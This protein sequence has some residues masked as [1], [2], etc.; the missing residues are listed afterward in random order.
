MSEFEY[1]EG[2][3]KGNAQTSSENPNCLGN[4]GQGHQPMTWVSLLPGDC[5]L[6]SR[7][8][9][10]CGW[11]TLIDRASADLPPRA[12]LC[13]RAGYTAPSELLAELPCGAS[14]GPPS[15]HGHTLCPHTPAHSSGL[16]RVPA[17]EL[18]LATTGSSTCGPAFAWGHCTWW[19]SSVVTFPGREAMRCT[20]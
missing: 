12:R 1:F 10:P 8:G 20:I 15:R 16:G 6:S 3:K 18:S 4:P 7:C 11:G 5:V 13:R 19:T 17:P 2:E 9:P 14:G